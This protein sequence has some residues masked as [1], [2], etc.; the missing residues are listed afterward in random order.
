MKNLVLFENFEASGYEL[1]KHSNKIND[2]ISQ[3][4]YYV[5]LLH[6]EKKAKIKSDIEIGYKSTE[7]EKNSSVINIQVDD[8]HFLRLIIINTPLF[9]RQLSIFKSQDIVLD[10]DSVI[11]I[12]NIYEDIKDYV[13]I[14]ESDIK[15]IKRTLTS[16]I[17]NNSEQI[18][19]Q[20]YQ[21]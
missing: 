14:N 5:S 13:G 3:K 1:K 15:T 8:F 7:T 20:D 11:D 17:K 9:G 16:R 19:F 4:T 18:I 6:R 10:N 12:I 2:I 21:L